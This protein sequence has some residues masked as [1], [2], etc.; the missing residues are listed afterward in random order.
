MN[1]SQLLLEERASFVAVGIAVALYCVAW[2][3]V[4]I[5]IMVGSLLN[6]FIAPLLGFA[7]TAMPHDPT[8]YVAIFFVWVVFFHFFIAYALEFWMN[9]EEKI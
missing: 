2:I 9:R 3:F 4:D 5:N 6:K 7:P 1:K 8:Q